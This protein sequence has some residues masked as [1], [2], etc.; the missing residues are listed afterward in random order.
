MHSA[1]YPDVD[2]LYEDIAQVYREEI[3]ALHVP[4]VAP[5]PQHFELFVAADVLHADLEQEAVELRNGQRIGPGHVARVLRRD[6]EEQLVERV[7]GYLT[8]RGLLA[9][10]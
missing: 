7:I 4:P 8:E 1:V 10:G 9:K 2:L 5:R 6:H 3:A